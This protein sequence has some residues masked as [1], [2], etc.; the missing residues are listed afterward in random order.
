[1]KKKFNIP[2]VFKVKAESETE[3]K[4][5]VDRLLRNGFD[6]IIEYERP[7]WKAIR[8]WYWAVIGPAK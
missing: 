6:A 8:H 4:E 1:M 3:A 5:Y 2:V 7:T